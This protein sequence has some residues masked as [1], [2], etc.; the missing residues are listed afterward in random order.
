M[1]AA[2]LLLAAGCAPDR[3]GPSA[4]LVGAWRSSV[5]F[6]TGT[7]AAV[8]GFEFLYVFNEGGTMTESSNYDAAPPVPPAY[9]IWRPVGAGELEA[10][11]EFFMTAPS[12]PEAFKTGAGWLPSGR[13]VLTERIKLSNDGQSFTSTIRFEAFDATGEP[14]EGSG[15]GKGKATRIQ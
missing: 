2:A 15:V 9:G 10:K 13:G 12:S 3:Q 11:Y 7:F 4:A 14:A 1:V 5:Q 8:K 6:D